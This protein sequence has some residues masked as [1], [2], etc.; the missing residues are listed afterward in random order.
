[1]G[2]SYPSS[3]QTSLADFPRAKAFFQTQWLGLCPFEKISLQIQETELGHSLGEA[4][5]PH[6]PN[7]SYQINLSPHLPSIHKELA[8]VHEMAHICRDFYHQKDPLWFSEGLAKLIEFHFTQVWPAHFEQS[9]NLS[10]EIFLATQDE[11]FKLRRIEERIYASPGYTSSFLFFVYLYNR[12]GK[13]DFIQILLQQPTSNWDAIEATLLQL[14]TLKN[15]SIPDHFL[16]KESLWTHFAM[17]LIYNSPGTAA[18]GLLQLDPQFRR[19]WQPKS[20]TQNSLMKEN[21]IQI[22]DHPAKIPSCEENCRLFLARH[23]ETKAASEPLI[24]E[25]DPLTPA[26]AHKTGTWVLIKYGPPRK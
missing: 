11:D 9:L 4:R 22:F 26:L 1:M 24:E 7:P 18:Y 15:F 13:K 12:F 5:R 3:A 2:L 8:V 17:A 25:F 14:K 16:T 21:S 6:S 20:E 19:R 10:N 23:L